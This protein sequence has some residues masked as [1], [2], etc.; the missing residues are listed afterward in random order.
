M[1]PAVLSQ[2]VQN[3][4]VSQVLHMAPGLPEGQVIFPSSDSTCPYTYDCLNYKV[5]RI[6]HQ[7]TTSH[8]PLSRTG[9]AQI[10]RQ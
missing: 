2:V 7:A 9:S 8:L 3:S 6:S 1:R 10:K 5:V 4:G